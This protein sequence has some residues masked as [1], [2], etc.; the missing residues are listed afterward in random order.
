VE[1]LRGIK[2]LGGDPEDADPSAARLAYRFLADL[3][4]IDRAEAQQQIVCIVSM[5]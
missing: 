1:D 3:V 2:D 5:D 4:M